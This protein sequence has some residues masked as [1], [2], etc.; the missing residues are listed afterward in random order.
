[1]PSRNSDQGGRNGPS[2]TGKAT[3]VEGRG[4]Q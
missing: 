4:A 2:G 3:V 1:M